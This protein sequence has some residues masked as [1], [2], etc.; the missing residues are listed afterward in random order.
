MPFLTEYFPVIAA[1]KVMAPT[2]AGLSMMTV[3]SQFREPEPWPIILTKIIL[4]KIT[5]KN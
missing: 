2:F 5:K 3:C 1:P 4:G